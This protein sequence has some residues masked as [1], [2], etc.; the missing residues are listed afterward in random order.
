M[1]KKELEAEN[2]F[3]IHCVEQ[4][5]EGVVSMLETKRKM[6]SLIE[7]QNKLIADQNKL[8]KE[9]RSSSTTQKDAE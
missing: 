8:I 4:L 6:R 3:L 2:L 5:G 1:K 9:L 7:D